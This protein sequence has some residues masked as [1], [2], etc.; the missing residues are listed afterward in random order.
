MHPY[1]EAWDP[2]LSN[3]FVYLVGIFLNYE[4][5]TLTDRFI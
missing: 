4:K 3:L 5:K 1:L 2:L